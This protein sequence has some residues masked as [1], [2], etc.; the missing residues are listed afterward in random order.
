MKSFFWATK[1]PSS[2]VSK[3][4]FFFG[5]HFSGALRAVEHDGKNRF[6]K[7]RRFLCYFGSQSLIMPIFHG[8]FLQMLL[9]PYES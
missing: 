5:T 9:I 4:K 1:G 7:Y 8:D 2:R 3:K 6:S